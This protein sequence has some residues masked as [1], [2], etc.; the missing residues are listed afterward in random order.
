M[1]ISYFTLNDTPF[2]HDET[3]IAVFTDNSGEVSVQCADVLTD[4]CAEFTK[5][6]I[7]DVLSKEARDFALDHALKNIC[8][9]DKLTST[10]DSGKIIVDCACCSASP[11]SSNAV[12]LSGSEIY[13]ATLKDIKLGAENGYICFG[14]VIDN[15]VVSAA[16]T[17]LS[18]VDIDAEVE[19]GV[20]TLPAYRGM[21]YASQCVGALTKHLSDKGIA[22]YYSYYEENS[23]SKN[24]AEKCGFKAFSRGF[25]IVLRKEK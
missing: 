18:E 25:E 23:A 22:V 6:F 5:R 8:F 21:G 2:E 7:S 15:K 4:F 14:I 11:K 9:Y 3:V 17:F 13:P 19:I 12:L 10:A 24:L 20:E 16:Y 1:E